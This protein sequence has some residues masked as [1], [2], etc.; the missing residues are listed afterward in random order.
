VHGNP[1][2]NASGTVDGTSSHGTDSHG[3]ATFADLVLDADAQS[4]MTL[5]FEVSG[6][7]GVTAT[8]NSFTVTVGSAASL[9]ATTATSV[10]A[11]VGQTD[12]DLSS[13]P[14]VRIKDHGDH[15]LVANQTVTWTIVGT[16]CPASNGPAFRANPATSTTDNSG[17]ATIP[18]LDLGFTII[19]S[20]CA[21]R[22]A[23]GSLTVDFQLTVNP[24]F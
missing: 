8:S 23:V 9:T 18:T 19:T 22:A 21:I 15:N 10:S 4:G 2:N 3:K 20:N 12:A 7:S 6:L 24:G 16:G 17:R 5:G 11:F 13:T 14:T 1:A